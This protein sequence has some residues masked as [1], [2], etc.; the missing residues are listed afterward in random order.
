MTQF[1]VINGGCN[2]NDVDEPH[3][4]SFCEADNLKNLIKHPTN[5]KDTDK[6]TCT[7]LILTN[8]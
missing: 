6:P 4:K 1:E 2:C 7:D 8:V 3:M 5:Y